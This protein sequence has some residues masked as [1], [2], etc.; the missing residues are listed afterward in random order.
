MNA[1]NSKQKNQNIENILEKVFKIY[2]P[3]ASI[4]ILTGGFIKLYVYY[5]Q[6][7]V[8]IINLVDLSEITLSFI[9][10]VIIYLFASSVFLAFIFVWHY[11]RVRIKKPLQHF[12]T[13]AVMVFIFFFTRKFLDYYMNLTLDGATIGYF[14]GL[15]ILDFYENV[16][17]KKQYMII[18][19][20]FLSFAFLSI[21]ALL[22]FHKA[23]LYK[24]SPELHSSSVIFNDNT[25]IKA[26]SNPYI[27][28]MTKHYLFAFDS[29]VNSAKWFP[30][31]SVR[32]M[33]LNNLPYSNAKGSSTFTSADIDSLR[34]VPYDYTGTSYTD[35]IEYAKRV[36]IIDSLEKI[37]KALKK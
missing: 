12:V 37:S 16:T 31:S 33:T 14:I 10:D 4:L 18:I 36:R 28:G 11:W 30:L 2:L 19:V 25:E 29:V 3:L 15:I 7:S 24:S 23:R 35:S 32:T 8:D 34:D 17:V 27:I 5:S 22:P 9:K 6:F 1:N 21:S 13:A 20:C 26:F